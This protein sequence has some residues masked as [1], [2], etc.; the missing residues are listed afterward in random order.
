MGVEWWT[1]DTVINETPHL[2]QALTVRTCEI[3]ARI[4]QLIDTLTKTPE[5]IEL[6]LEVIR[7]AKAVD[8]DVA[9]WQQN[10]GSAEDWRPKTIAWE[11]SVTDGDYANAEV[12]PGRVDV[13]NDIWIGSVSNQA[14]TIRL[15]LHATIVRCAAWVCSPVD[16][17]TTPEYATASAVCRN[18]ITDIIASVPYYMG[19]HLK[20]TNAGTTTNISSFACGEE[21]S[22]KGLAGYL[23]T[24]PLS[25][26]LSQDHAT[27]AQRAWA[28]GRLRK[29]GSDLGVKYALAVSQV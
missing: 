6:M 18:A 29:I 26:V 20:R 10:Y 16:Y 11:D 13:Y 27:D 2:I 8:Q 23:I 15:L 24:W 21:D 1:D 28:L 5:N 3:R 17:R 14:H 22:V 19:W 7:K 25:C 4:A 9:A 12:F